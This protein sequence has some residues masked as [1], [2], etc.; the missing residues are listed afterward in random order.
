MRDREY[1][2]FAREDL[3]ELRE[4]KQ[5]SAS[6]GE[7]GV[8]PL[9][10]LLGDAT[11]SSSSEL[12]AGEGVFSIFCVTDS[13]CIYKPFGLSFFDLKARMLWPAII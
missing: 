13:G 5:D 2:E 10:L 9:G 3:M 6:V 1:T 4:L 7:I 12:L 8:C 11:G